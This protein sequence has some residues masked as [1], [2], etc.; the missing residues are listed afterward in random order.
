MHVLIIWVQP[1]FITTFRLQSQKW[2]VLLMCYLLR[3][4]EI[5][6][7]HSQCCVI[8]IQWINGFC[9]SKQDHEVDNNISGVDKKAENFREED[10]FLARV[11]IERAYHLPKQL[12]NKWEP[13]GIRVVVQLHSLNI[14]FVAVS[15]FFQMLM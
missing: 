15:K 3:I 8:M 7:L 12:E 2:Y 11:A 6:L 10:N 14:I 9:S 13:F 4:Y 1:V 5:C